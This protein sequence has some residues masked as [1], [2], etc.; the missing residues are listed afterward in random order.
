MMCTDHSS[1]F[2]E[3]E[4]GRGELIIFGG[5]VEAQEGRNLSGGLFRAVTKTDTDLEYT[6]NR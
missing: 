2:S 1:G 6:G 5:M 3:T 4:E